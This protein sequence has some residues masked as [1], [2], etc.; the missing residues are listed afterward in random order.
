MMQIIFENESLNRLLLASIQEL[1]GFFY[2]EVEE[3]A[4]L[5]YSDFGIFL[6]DKIL[7]IP[8][9]RDLITKSFQFLN[10]LVDKG[11]SEVVTMLRVTTFEIL[12]DDPQVIAV[13]KQHLKDKALQVFLKV[14]EF[15]KG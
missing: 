5:G 7:E 10:L 4:Y 6:R 8:Q 13:A 15:M 11:D 14:I 1:E 3:S 2:N 12:T 9:N